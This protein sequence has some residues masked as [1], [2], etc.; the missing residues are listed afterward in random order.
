MS[1]SR[2]VLSLCLAASLFGCGEKPA[3][4][5][6]GYVEAEYVRL[7][8]PI[9]GTLVKLSVQRGDRIARDAPTFTLEQDN[10]RSAR[11]DAQAR[12]GRAEATLAD[13][14][15]GRRPD[16]VSVV[17]AQVAQ[18]EASLSLSQAA[19]ARENT[20]L[21]ARFVAPARVDELRATVQR[22]EARVR[23]A[24]AQA[25]VAGLGA[26]SDAL[27]AA[28][29]DV[30]SA[31]ALLVQ[32][33]WRL[34]QKT[35]RAPLAAEVVDVL[36]REGEFVP[37]GVPVVSLLAPGNVLARFFVPQERLGALALGQDVSLSC[38][39]CPR[40]LAAKVSYIASEPEYTAPLIYSKENR[41][42]LVFMVEAR[43][44]PADA[45]TLHPGQ[46]LEIRL[47]APAAAAAH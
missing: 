38:D 6:P 25:R 4:F 19:L 32:A 41:A 30:A 17:Q 34:A 47:L 13:L 20:L 7:A 36:Y 46:P 24:R 40:A 14:R 1:I 11:V 28:Q 21:A 39:G 23:E 15:K 29:Q 22:D 5:Y 44:A 18:A 42:T 8:S 26:R 2:S 33:D 9:A 16:E 37:A 12:L 45:S 10:E 35:Q 27:A 43:T 3:G 31:Q